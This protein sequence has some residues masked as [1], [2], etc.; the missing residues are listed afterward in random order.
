M[1]PQST[2]WPPLAFLAIRT[3]QWP[4]VN[5]LATTGLLGH[6]AHCWS[7]ANPAGLQVLQIL[8]LNQV[9]I[10]ISASISAIPHRDAE[11]LHAAAVSYLE[12]PSLLV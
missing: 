10:L 6:E 12:V 3:N 4:T 11:P 1:G 7:M 9:L 2:C 8:S 5:L